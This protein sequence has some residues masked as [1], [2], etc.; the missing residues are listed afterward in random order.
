MDERQ[1]AISRLI[2]IN[3]KAN[4]TQIFLFLKAHTHKR[5]RPA[6]EM[7]GSSP[8]AFARL[9]IRHAGISLAKY[10]SVACIMSDA[11]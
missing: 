3:D 10:M 4:K 6:K 9:Q 7:Q 11:P 2:L 8:L 5:A 1:S